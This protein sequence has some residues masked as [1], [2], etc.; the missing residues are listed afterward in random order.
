MES[1]EHNLGMVYSDNAASPFGVWY[2]E[3][4]TKGECSTGLAQQ[5]TTTT[6]SNCTE[7]AVTSTADDEFN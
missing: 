1:K 6:I 2:E 3:Q 5:D 7:S 4:R